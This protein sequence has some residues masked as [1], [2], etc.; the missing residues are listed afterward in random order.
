MTELTH[1]SRKGWDGQERI[2]HVDE[3]PTESD[4]TVVDYSKA[5]KPTS[6]ALCCVCTSDQGLVVGRESGA[7]QYY[8]LPSVTL[9]G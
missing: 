5:A 9:E 2:I 3:E 1:L 7:L 8:S 4:K 6:D